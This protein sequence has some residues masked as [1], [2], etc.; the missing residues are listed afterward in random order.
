MELWIPITLAAA[1]CQNARSTFQKLLQGRLGTAGATFSRFCYGVPF[2]AGY[3]LILAAGFGTPLPDA[4]PFFP[5]YVALAGLTQILATFLLV[6]LFKYRNF[7]VGTAYSKTEP[8]LAAGFGFLVLGEGNGWPLLV[9]ILAGIVGVVLVSVRRCG[10]VDRAIPAWLF[11]RAAL[12]GVS[13]AALFGLSAVFVRGASLSLSG[14]PVFM[15]AACA[16]LAVTLFQTLAMGGWMFVRAR[17]EF[18]QVLVSWRQAI[19][20]GAAGIAA[21]I[22]W[23]TAMTLQEVAYVR[24]LAQ[25]ELVFTLAVSWLVFRERLAASELSGCILIGSS[26]AAVVLLS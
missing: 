12:I 16:L 1:F 18:L 21:S 22:G 7:A 26:A 3:V 4:A 13:S 11:S 15:Q 9:S 23:F 6:Y 2:V 8:L 14:T 5:V 25:V 24:A 17:A 19:W 10:G 20:A